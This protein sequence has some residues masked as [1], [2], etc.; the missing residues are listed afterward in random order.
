MHVES[1]RFL[2][3]SPF[4]EKAPEAVPRPARGGGVQGHG[5]LEEIRGSRRRVAV[6]HVR[7]LT[8]RADGRNR[9]GCR[10]LPPPFPRLRVGPFPPPLS[11][12]QRSAC[13]V[14]ANQRFARELRRRGSKVP[15]PAGAGEG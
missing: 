6:Q 10:R 2:Q 15:S 13:R 5:D 14:S 3:G 4:G 1:H 8:N 7:T 12:D 9:G 11:A